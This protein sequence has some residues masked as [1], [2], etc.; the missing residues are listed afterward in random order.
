VPEVAAVE[1]PDTFL[2]FS[3]HSVY[4]PGLGVDTDHTSLKYNKPIQL[5][6][7]R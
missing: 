6:F 7:T 1:S 4:W 2:F 3:A 5:S